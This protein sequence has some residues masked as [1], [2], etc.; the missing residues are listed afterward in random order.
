MK[1]LETNE[2][3]SKMETEVSHIKDDVLEMKEK[4]DGVGNSINR[5]DM[6]ITKL[7]LI[8]EQ[9]QQ[10]E[11]RV[12]AMEH[13]IARWGGVIAVI[14]AASGLFGSEATEI[15]KGIIGQ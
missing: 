1:T 7:A 9:N 10:I 6:A 8:A 5:I 15:V 12:K 3:L 11:P 13:K 4:I 2:R 14:V